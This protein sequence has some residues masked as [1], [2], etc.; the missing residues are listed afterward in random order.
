L[1]EA[2]GY[3]RRQIEI[4]ERGQPIVTQAKPQPAS[5]ALA[6]AIAL[7]LLGAAAPASGHHSFIPHFD[8]EA[9]VTLSGTVVRFEARNPHAYLHVEVIG[10]DGQPQVWVCESHGVTMLER[11]GVTRDVLAPGTRLTVSGASARRDPRGCFFRTIELA[12]GRVLSADGP[13][14][15]PV[16]AAAPQPAPAAIEPQAGAAGSIYG[17]WLLRPRAGGGGGQQDPMI[18]ALT[19]AG[20]RASEAYDPYTDD[21]VLRCDTIGI[22]RVWFA[23]GTP[24]EI[25]REGD[26]VR[27]RAEWM[28]AER[29]I[30]LD[31][32]RFPEP[33][34]A[35]TL[36]YS[37]GR[38]D[39][40]TLV[41]DTRY[42]RGGII[43]QYVQRADGTQIGL[44][45][46]DQMT[47]RERVRVDPETGLLNVTIESHDPVYYTRP[48][49]P[50][51]ATYARS[52]LALQPFG[53]TP[54]VD[55]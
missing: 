5:A 3:N 12:D 14:P 25:R 51:T 21:P 53:C 26:R 8:P 24:L 48:F 34:E 39:G 1:L 43:S 37:I 36:G 17:T 2:E 29:T 44:L 19:E 31:V 15:A 49:P 13:A 28:D 18:D 16:L 27:I 7:L 11:N 41:I 33:L 42:A 54:E 46:T 4:L 9:P 35:G 47:T 6:P 45:H 10:S 32:E 30:H 40:D 23:V 20:R 52:E 50:V 22:R 38:F 55:H